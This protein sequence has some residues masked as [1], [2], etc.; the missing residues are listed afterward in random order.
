MGISLKT[1]KMLW[2]RSGGRCSMPDCKKVLVV[3]ETETDNPS[4]VGDEAHIVASEPTEPRGDSPLTPEERDRYDNLILLCKIHHK[5]VDDQPN[6]YTIG[7]LHQI[8]HDHIEWFKKTAE[9][10]EVKQQ[11][12]EVYATYIER[13]IRLANLNEWNAWSSFIFG[14]GLPSMK[15]SLYNQLRELVEYILSRIWPNRYKELES[16]FTNFRCVLNDFLNVFSMHMTD[17]Y[18]NEW[19]WTEK[20][21]Q[22]H[23]WDEKRYF[24]LSRKFDYHVS[25]V[26]DLMLEL[27]RA[28]NYVCDKI[29]KFISPSFRLDEGILLITSGPDINFRYLTS[30]VEYQDKEKTKYLY[31]GLKKFMTDRTTRDRYYGE[32]YS[33][34]YFPPEN[35]LE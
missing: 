15:T 8:K 9:Y 3:D 26:E 13:W 21:Y 14:G 32:G 16:T 17:Q 10:D 11:D 34:D 6:Y 29:R 25:L 1:H 31:P 12:D 7:R 18:H 4:I 5:I 33:P 24:A 30:R 2:G 35:F 19:L 23:E 20:F 27:T 28:A 22:I